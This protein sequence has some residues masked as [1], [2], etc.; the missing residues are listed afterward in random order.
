MSQTE[1]EAKKKQNCIAN[2]QRM[3]S[4][5]KSVSMGCLASCQTSDFSVTCPTRRASKKV[6]LESCILR[7]TQVES[8]VNLKIPTC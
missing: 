1:Y 2:W 4:S 5:G 8:E 6:N 7:S 3:R